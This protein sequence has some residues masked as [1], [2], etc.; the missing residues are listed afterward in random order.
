[1]GGTIS[2][3]L[4]QPIA[5]P[6]GTP[7]QKNQNLGEPEMRFA[8]FAFRGRAAGGP[9]RLSRGTSGFSQVPPVQSCQRTPPQGP[10]APARTTAAPGLRARLRE[11][12]PPGPATR[13]GQERAGRG[14]REGGGARG[15]G[16]AAA[17]GRSQRPGVRAGAGCRP[18]A[19]LAE[20]HDVSGPGAAA[21]RRRGWGWGW[22]RG[23][24]FALAARAPLALR[25][26]PRP[27]PRPGQPGRPVAGAGPRVPRAAPVPQRVERAGERRPGH[28]Q[29]RQQRRG[30]QR[31]AV[32]RLRLGQQR[33][34]VPGRG[35]ARRPAPLLEPREPA[36]HHRR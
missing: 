26:R 2:K 15:S 30:Q 19:S 17:E 4:L 35:H 10:E 36:L 18:G 29:Q 25:Q 32:A 1:M 28:Q 20:P 11:R 5:Q 14:G 33:R 24:R 27:R 22:G 23:R 16:R 12:V 34:G 3:R 13:T 8:A 31:R 7:K 9:E 6:G 21:R